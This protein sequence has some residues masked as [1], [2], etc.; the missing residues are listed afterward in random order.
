MAVQPWRLKTGQLVALGTSAVILGGYQWCNRHHSVDHWY[1]MHHP[2]C[3]GVLRAALTVL[4]LGIVLN[5]RR[6]LSGVPFAPR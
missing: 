3:Y 1:R 2:R 5:A 6:L 4:W